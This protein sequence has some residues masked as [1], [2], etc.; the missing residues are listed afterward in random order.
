MS[1][2]LVTDDDEAI[3][4]NYDSVLTFRVGEKPKTVEIKPNDIENNTYIIG[5]YS[6]NRDATEH[7]HGVLT[8]NY[9]MLA[10]RSIESD[11]PDDMIIYYKYLVINPM[12]AGHGLS[13]QHNSR[14]MVLYE[15][16]YS[17]EQ[18]EQVLERLSP[19]RQAQS[20]YNRTVYYH[21]ITS[22]LGVDEKVWESLKAKKDV[23]KE[24]IKFFSE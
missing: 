5:D 8:T 1:K 20:G 22:D 24:L 17:V 7:Y 13:L 10:S 9:I 21:Y 15:P 2:I 11:N 23:E 16:F 18:Y 12:S 3:F 4:S 6:F 14:R 19:I